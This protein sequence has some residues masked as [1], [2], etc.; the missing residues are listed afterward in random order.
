MIAG[1]LP[2]ISPAALRR[3][4]VAAGRAPGIALVPDRHFRGTNALLC[5][6]PQ[7]IAPC[8]GP[9]SYALHLDAAAAAGVPARVLQIDELALDL[10]EPADLEYLQAHHVTIIPVARAASRAT[11]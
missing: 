7:A 6:P 4:F 2:L 9:D 3:L 11:P 1:D 10:D 8:F 5:T